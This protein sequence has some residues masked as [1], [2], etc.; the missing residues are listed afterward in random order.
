MEFIE[1]F[2]NA[3]SRIDSA[4]AY[5]YII[6][7]KYDKKANC[8]PKGQHDDDRLLAYLINRLELVVSGT[9]SILYFHS[10]DEA[11]QLDLTFLSKAYTV[12]SREYK[13]N[14]KS[15][16]VVHPTFWVKM[17][18][19]FCS[20]FMDSSLNANIVVCEKITD[21]YR[22]FEQ[23]GLPVPQIVMQADQARAKWF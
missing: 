7:D 17:A 5:V 13:H 19:F 22:D 9:Y 21:L 12:L 6:G 23:D 2:E 14:L 15:L 8:D 10:A 1:L 11:H 4:H 20:P 16:W 3:S 18:Y